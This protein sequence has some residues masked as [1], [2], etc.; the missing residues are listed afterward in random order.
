MITN[1]LKHT[2]ITERQT[3]TKRGDKDIRNDHNLTQNDHKTQRDIEQPQRDT[4][5]QRHKNDHK[6]TDNN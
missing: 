1:S 4:Q 5:L 6:E 2:V 3:I